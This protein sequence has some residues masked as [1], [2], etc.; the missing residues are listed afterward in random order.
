MC[1]RQQ[2][3]EGSLRDEGRTVVPLV[4]EGQRSRRWE[5]ESGGRKEREV[6]VVSGMVCTRRG[7][8]GVK[9]PVLLRRLPQA[10]RVGSSYSARL[11]IETR[12][13]FRRWRQRD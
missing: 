12:C 3:K 9:M 11:S 13:N 6:G 10:G 1:A 8:G 4:N 5:K 7:G 2:Q